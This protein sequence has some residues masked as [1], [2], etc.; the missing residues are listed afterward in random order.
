MSLHDYRPFG[1]GQLVAGGSDIV[2]NLHY[3]TTGRAATTRVKIGFTLAKQPLKK[4]FI[5][6]APSGA[7]A[8]FA[9]P[10]NEPNYRAP[11]VEI[12]IRNDA[13]LL[14]PTD[15]P[16]RGRVGCWRGSGKPACHTGG[17]S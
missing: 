1:A 17:T 12:Q 16:R 7:T 3:Q 14:A 11:T 13:E 9:I 5:Q 2:L 4:K 15:R 8:Q 10:P 6:L